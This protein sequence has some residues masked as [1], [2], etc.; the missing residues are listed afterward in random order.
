MAESLLSIFEE[1]KILRTY[2][3]KIGPKRRLGE[4]RLRKLNEARDLFSKYTKANDI[5]KNQI[6]QGQLDKNEVALI[7][8]INSNFNTVYSEILTL[9]SESGIKAQTSK[10]A[11]G[12]VDSDVFNLKTALTLLP[13]MSDDELSVKQLIDSVEYYNS[14]LTKPEC[15]NKLITFVLKNRLSQCAKLKLSASYETVDGLLNDMRKIL[16]PKK[17]ST[18]LL[19]KLQ[20][21]KQ[22]DKSISDFGREIAELFVDL[23]ISQADGDMAKQSILK[24]INEKLA[25]KRF[26]DGLRNRRLSTIV[27]ARDFGSLTEAIQG[28]Q[29]EEVETSPSTEFVGTYYS[30]SIRNSNSPRGYR[31]RYNTYR[32][33]RGLSQRRGQQQQAQPMQQPALRS[34]SSRGKPRGYRPHR[35]FT[36]KTN[37]HINVMSSSTHHQPEQQ[38]RNNTISDTDNTPSSETLNHFFRT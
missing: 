23:T 17:S 5:I 25:I 24:P 32:A 6:V 1:L 27:A 4:V 33:A 28:A 21:T 13:L 36:C 10:M 16:L 3:I 34:T 2:L 7:F 35:Y 11:L 18:A 19:S 9:C 15:K 8:K 38:S 29:D 14:L 26:A 22:N 31:G 20:S 12:D 30:K 37:R